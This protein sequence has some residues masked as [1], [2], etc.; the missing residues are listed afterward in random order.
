[1][2]RDG[3]EIGIPRRT[4]NI[5]DLDETKTVPRNKILYRTS[6]RDTKAVASGVAF[7]RNMSTVFGGPDDVRTII[8]SKMVRTVRQ[9][10]SAKFSN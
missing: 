1:M 7:G 4:T 10:H 5:R 2:C 8:L 3:R 9:G 6:K